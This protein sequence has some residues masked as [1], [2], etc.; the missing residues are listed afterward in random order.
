MK[1]GVRE[2]RAAA[3]RSP[4]G[5]EAGVRRRAKD[6]ILARLGDLRA[7]EGCVGQPDNVAAHHAMRIAAKRLRYTL[8]VFRP[9]FGKALEKFIAAA[10]HAQQMLGEIHDCD[11]WVDFLPRFLEKERAR[12]AGRKGAAKRMA[13]AKPGLAFLEEDRR[14]YRAQR[15]EA[16]AAFWQTLRTDGLWER[17]VALAGAPPAAR[18][19]RRAG[20]APSQAA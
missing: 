3:R 15:F 13:R 5:R 4:A 9:L 8:E 14:R 17:L 16:F 18:R 20:A 10:R 6:A 19:S 12:S 7:L 1:R 2:A 11:V